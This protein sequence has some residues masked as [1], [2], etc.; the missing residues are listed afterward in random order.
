[1]FI[2]REKELADLNALY[3]TDKFQMPVIYGRR[4]V[5]KSTLIR[6]FVE[7]KKAVLFTKIGRWWGTNPKL[8]QEEEI[9]IVGVNPLTKCVL[10]G[11]CKYQ[12][13]GI[14]FET[15]KKLMDR[16]LLI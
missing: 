14:H 16:G 13:Q 11:E 9:D 5:G 3:D 6:K 10:L 1:M 12:N 4:R 15:A 7:D 2:G 8:K